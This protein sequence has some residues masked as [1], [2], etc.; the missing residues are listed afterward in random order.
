MQRSAAVVGALAS[1]SGAGLAAF[2]AAH[3][4]AL[5]T[6]LGIVLAA[7]GAMGAAAL[8][9]RREARERSRLAEAVRRAFAD[10]RGGTERESGA[11]TEELEGSVVAAIA[12]LERL[13]KRLAVTERIAARRE[14][15]R[16]VAHEIKNPL[17][18]IRA[19]VETL[20]RLHARGD[21]RFD[22]VF[23]DATRTVLEEVHRITRIVGDFTEFSRMPAPR[24]EPFDFVAAARDVVALHAA[25]PSAIRTGGAMAP[26][27]VELAASAIGALRGDRD[28][29]VRVLTNLVQ[30]G[31]E[32]AS[33]TRSDPRVLVTIEPK[34][35]THVRVVV[36]D[37]GPGVAEEMVE[38][39]FEP[40]A[41]SKSTGTGLGLA[42]CQR[43]VFEHGGE[44]GYR[45][46]TKGGAVFEIALPLAGPSL[47]DRPIEATGNPTTRHPGR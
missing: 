6:A 13:K 16:Q 17:A 18:P 37:N 1:G 3:G 15:A 23:D 44:I 35:E 14:I 30:N 27:R 28:Q 21:A 22:E 33:A 4:H 2:G 26:P 47:L 11:A 5:A 7:A 9:A 8:G 19:S 45:P 41:T 32:A 31:L 34:G 24:L 39:L 40:Y 46:A 42:I 12:E 38:R 29:L 36:R 10:A 43:V 20:R 25:D